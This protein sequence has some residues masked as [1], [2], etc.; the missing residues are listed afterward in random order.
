MESARSARRLGRALVRARPHRH[1]RAPPLVLGHECAG[2]VAAVGHDVTGHAVGAA[3]VAGARACPTGRCRQCRAGR[4]N[5]CADIAL[6]RHPAVDGA[7]AEHRDD[8]TRTSPTRCPTRCPTTSGRCWSR[9][10]SASGPAARRTVSAG[11]R[12]LVTGAGPIGLLAMQSRRRSAPPTWRSPTSTSTGSRAAERSGATA[13][14]A[15]RA[16]TR[17]RSCSSWSAPGHP[18]RVDGRIEALR[19]RRARGA[20]RDG[21]KRRVQCR[22]PRSR[23]ASC[24]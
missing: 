7:F 13:T 11:D 1:R 20:G 2:R 4:Y 15:A 17:R 14:P 16:P 12:V 10:R 24:G 9:C 18:D 8:R 23:T 6:L 3:G 19:S 5:L 22:W 21:P